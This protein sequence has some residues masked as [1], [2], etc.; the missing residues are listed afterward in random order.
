[1]KRVLVTGA[2]GFIGRNLVTALR[3]R[4]DLDVL[5]CG[6]A[7]PPGRMEE[8][9]STAEAVVHLAGV[10][11]P[12]DENEFVTGNVELTRQLCRAL[13]RAGRR[14]TLILTS[15]IQAELDNPYGRSKRAAEVLAEAYQQSAGAA[16]FIYRLP[17]VFGK[18]SRPHY[19]TVVA[20]F[21]HQISR[22]LPVHISDPARRLRLVY[23]DD[24][25]RSFEGVLL[26]PEVVPGCYRPVVE[27]EFSITLEELHDRIVS[28]RD[29]GARGC[30]PDL[31]DPFQ[32]ALYATYLSFC[33]PANLARSV[34]IKRDARG[35][36]FELVKSV[37][38]GQVF[39]S[40]TRP[41]VT[42]GHHYHD[43]KVEKFCVVQG[44][45]R[46]RLRPV[47]G[48]EILEYEVDDETI[49]VVEIPPGYTHSIENIGSV[50]LITLFWASE[51]FDPARPDTHPLPVTECGMEEDRP[52]T[53]MRTAQKHA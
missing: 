50:D 17:N 30:V 20:T 44:R 8:L 18:W 41:G 32:R 49:R 27:P 11:R 7:D 51:I 9:A 43:T 33:D 39:V 3:R 1:M 35:W 5:T 21:C 24:V 19:N 47:H 48:S 12:A 36:L 6:R 38:A 28:F 52:D 2:S 34:E 40:L 16:V 10:N 29:A 26:Q 31:S 25:V 14:A 13:E 4:G 15:S 22:G 46:I 37:Q 42:R 23:I 45:G 53:R